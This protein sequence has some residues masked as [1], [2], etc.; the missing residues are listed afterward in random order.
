M[1]P[2]IPFWYRLCLVIVVCIEPI[3]VGILIKHGALPEGVRS[4]LTSDL[5]AV[6]TIVAWAMM[7]GAVH[8]AVV[9]RWSTS[10]TESMAAT[11]GA[12]R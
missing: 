3:L 12:A 8:N 4:W 10:R 11:E 6:A 5:G 1:K 9:G 2:L 7:V